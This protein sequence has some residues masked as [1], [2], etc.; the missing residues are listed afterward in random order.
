[1]G[2]TYIS[3]VWEPSPPSAPG[4]CP[5]LIY[6]PDHVSPAQSE[7]IFPFTLTLEVNLRP[8]FLAEEKN[9]FPIW[10]PWH[11]IDSYD[12]RYSLW[13]IILT[14]KF[15]PPPKKMRTRRV[16][17]FQVSIF[18]NITQKQFG[19]LFYNFPCLKFLI[20]FPG[21]A[22]RTPPSQTLPVKCLHISCW[23][24]FPP[25]TQRSYWTWPF[26][27]SFEHPRQTF[28]LSLCAWN[29]LP[30]LSWQHIWQGLGDAEL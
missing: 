30:N 1:M 21:L 18:T 10:K 20:A 8:C 13:Y 11:I 5:W 23:C 2:G 6:F 17:Y 7:F 12:N 24:A 26:V 9:T 28:P 19:L 27:S 3:L 16:V 25:R 22:P 4:L 14:A 15:Y 29:I